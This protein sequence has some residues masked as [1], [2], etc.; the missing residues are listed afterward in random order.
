ML[1]SAKAKE[2]K[3]EPEYNLNLWLG[4]MEIEILETFQYLLWMM[5]YFSNLLI[6]GEGL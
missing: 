4:R 5:M 6:I 3:K 1:L 2:S